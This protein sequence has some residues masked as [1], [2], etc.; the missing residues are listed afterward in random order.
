MNPLPLHFYLEEVE[1][2]REHGIIDKGLTIE[3]DI[4]EFVNNSKIPTEAILKFGNELFFGN[5]QDVLNIFG[6]I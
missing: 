3:L 1:Q 2:D 6:A 4:S 5:S